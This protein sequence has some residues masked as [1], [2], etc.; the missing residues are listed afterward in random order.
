MAKTVFPERM[1][2]TSFSI[3]DVASRLMYFQDQL[4]LLH[5]ATTSYAQHE[6]LGKLYGCVYEFKDDAV[7][8][9]MGYLGTRPKSLTIPQLSHSISPT[10]VVKQIGSFADSLEIWA[11]ANGYADIEGM[12]QQ[13]SGSAAKTM[14]LLTLK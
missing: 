5:W 2:G 10:E 13:L 14:Y 3:E 6:A 1:L 8:K 12:A 11:K 9:L 4:Q 7:E